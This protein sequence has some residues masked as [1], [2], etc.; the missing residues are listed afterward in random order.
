MAD[1]KSF[2]GTGLL[3]IIRGTELRPQERIYLGSTYKISETGESHCAN[4]VHLSQG[5]V[6]I[7]LH[8]F[9][10]VFYLI[11]RTRKSDSHVHPPVA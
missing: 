1:F 2:Y 4:I 9:P 6:Q 10:A 3:S 8:R 5:G 7:F 11:V